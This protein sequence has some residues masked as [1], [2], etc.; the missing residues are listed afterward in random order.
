[1]RG[2]AEATKKREAPKKTQIRI[3]EELIKLLPSK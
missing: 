1:M 3:G 2:H